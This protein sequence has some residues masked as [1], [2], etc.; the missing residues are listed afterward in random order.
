MSISATLAN[1]LTGLTAASRGAQVVST[2]IAN[3]NTEGFARRDIEQSARIVG[4]IGAGVQVDGINRF[5]DETVLRER[6]LADAA[7]GDASVSS[8]FYNGLLSLVGTPEDAA[9][10]S[11]DITNF[12]TS[13]LEASFRPE[14]EARLYSVLTAAQTVT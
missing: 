8:N 10:L 11:S 9:S 1:A 4:G 3:A 2:N 7:V 13:L 5:V 6:R 14:S 12:E